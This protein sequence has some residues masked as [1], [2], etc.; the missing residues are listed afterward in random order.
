M[1][2]ALAA[3]AALGL[4]SNCAPGD[5]EAISLRA[6]GKVHA[7]LNTARIGYYG[8]TRSFSGDATELYTCPDMP[9]ILSGAGVFNKAS[10]STWM[11]P[12]ACGFARFAAKTGE[13]LIFGR[14]DCRVRM[15]LTTN[16]TVYCETV[17]NMEAANT[18]VHVL[19]VY[20]GTGATDADKCK[21]FI[22]GVNQTENYASP[23]VSISESS[24]TLLIGGQQIGV[25]GDT[26]YWYSDQSANA[27]AIYNGGKGHDLRK[28]GPVAFYTFD[29]PL[30][31]GGASGLLYDLTGNGYT[32]S[33]T[34]TETTDIVTDAP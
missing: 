10:I 9:A 28:F 21:I 18:W 27:T 12:A 30:D 31:A 6:K 29:H 7:G 32:C 26:A 8:D 22:N 17:I 15:V 11:K 13:L 20:N 16:S 25:Y 4:L 34:N 14:A 24:S 33:N 19:G 5:A 2:K 1:L 23:P 3:C